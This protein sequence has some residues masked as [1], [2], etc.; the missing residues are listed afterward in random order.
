MHENRRRALRHLG[1]T[2]AAGALGGLT[3]G[4]ARAQADA[5]FP[6]RPVRVIYPF[7]PGG[8]GDAVARSLFN[9]VGQ[10][11]GQPVVIENRPGAGGLI[12]ADQV[13]KAEP[14]GHTLLFTFTALVQVPSLVSKPPFNPIRDFAPVSELAT[15]HVVLVVRPEIPARTVKEFVTY[16]RSQGRAFPYGTYGVGSTGHLLMEILAKQAGMEMSAVAYKGEAPLLTDM[17]G[18]QVAAGFLSSTTAQQYVRAGK[19]RPLAVAGDDRSPLLPDV[20]NFRESG[21]PQVEGSG[22]LGLFAPAKTP[23]PLVERISADVNRALAKPEVRK[24]M[25]DYGLVVRGTTPAA[26]T[27]AVRRQH[28]YWANAIRSSN[29]R[30]D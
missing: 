3:A 27:E 14:D 10:A 11:W 15:T 22:W 24:K 9:T 12:G 26:F 17:L 25:E 6:T 20:P 1:G 29:I 13:A 16:V 30:L 5:P 8:M 2:I 7:N 21:Y 23:K 18:G 19:L 4:L 28:V